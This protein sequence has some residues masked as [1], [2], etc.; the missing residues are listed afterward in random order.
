MTKEFINIDKLTEEELINIL[1]T[2]I[3]VL[4]IVETDNVN[5]KSIKV[6][7]I[8][9][10]KH[11]TAFIEYEKEIN[12]YEQINKNKNKNYKKDTFAGLGFI[13]TI[14]ETNDSLIAIDLITQDLIKD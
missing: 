10:K 3:Y 13:K 14:I 11:N 8:V 5:I 7:T 1:K 9:F 2:P 6:K 12:K 4:R